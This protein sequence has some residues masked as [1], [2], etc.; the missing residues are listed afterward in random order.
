[1]YANEE[2]CEMV[3]LCGHCNRNKRKV[4]SLYTIKFPS[5]RYRSY[6]TTAR[7]VQRLHKTGS[8]YRRIPSFRA[9]PSSL[10]IS[11]EDVLGYAPAHPESS[12]RDISKACSYSKSTVWNILHT[13]IAYPYRPVL[14]QELMPGDQERRFD[15]CNFVLNTLDE[16][17]D[18]FNEVLWSDEC[19]FSRPESALHGTSYVLE[20][21]LHVPNHPGSYRYGSDEVLKCRNGCLVQQKEPVNSLKNHSHVTFCRHLRRSCDVEHSCSNNVSVTTVERHARYIS[22]AH[23]LLAC[24]PVRLNASSSYCL[25]N[26]SQMT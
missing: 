3:L 6:C 17:P 13:C 22:H 5:R 20:D 18:F 12:V 19:Q 11:A 16:N 21:S 25:G 23:I 10:R 4:A 24:R 15:S 14:A 2:F 9:T 26:C 1:M 8:C 7:G